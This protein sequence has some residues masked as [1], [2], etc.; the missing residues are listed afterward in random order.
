MNTPASNSVKRLSRSFTFSYHTHHDASVCD[1]MLSVEHINALLEQ[2]VQFLSVEKKWK[3]IFGLPY[4]KNNWIELEKPNSRFMTFTFKIRFEPDA[5][6][7][8]IICTHNPFGF[9]ALLDTALFAFIGLTIS[10]LT[11]LT[12]FS[13]DLARILH[14][15]RSG[16]MLPPILCG[17]AFFIIGVALCVVHERRVRG[18]FD[19]FLMKVFDAQPIE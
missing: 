14:D 16:S 13:E 4:P 2:G 9:S 19:D 5:T 1:G 17:F 12:P 15:S 10:V 7:T 11:I 3:V 6:G 18:I 8:T